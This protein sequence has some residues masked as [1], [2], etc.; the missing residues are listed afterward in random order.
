MCSPNTKCSQLSISLHF[1]CDFG[2][3]CVAQNTFYRFFFRLFLYENPVMARVATNFYGALKPMSLHHMRLNHPT[4]THTSHRCGLTRQFLYLS[5][6]YMRWYIF[7]FLVPIST[8]T[9]TS[10]SSLR[11]PISHFHLSNRCVRE[12]RF[13]SEKSISIY[14]YDVFNAFRMSVKVVILFNKNV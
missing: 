9:Y 3:G 4:H 6:I 5:K 12:M 14:I 7:Y 11:Y 13:S 1:I 2:I 10:I 8:Y